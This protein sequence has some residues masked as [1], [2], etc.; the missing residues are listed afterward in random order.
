MKK[1]IYAAA[2]AVGLVIAWFVVS[3]QVAVAQQR[4]FLTGVGP[5]SRIGVSVRD[6][7][8][9]DADK[10]KLAQ[11]VGAFV[12]SV[13]ENSPAAKAGLQAGDIIL[14]VDGERVRSVRH[15]TRLVEESAPR[16]QVPVVIVRGTSKQ[17]LNVVPES[18]PFP[19]EFSDDRLR[20]LPRQLGEL[21]RRLPRGFDFDIDPN[22]PVPR[23]FRL[24]P[25]GP[26]LGVS[27]SPLTDQLAQYFGVTDGALVSSVEANTPA[28][29]AGLK[30]GDVITAIDG[31]TVTSAGDITDALR[32]ARGENVEISVTRERKSLTLKAT[33]ARP[34]SGR[35]GLPV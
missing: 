27:V 23:R 17:T 5:A 31:R 35:R 12:E 1:S 19:R 7:T 14:D 22:A 15:F 34:S 33:P 20:D 25:G 2:A 6:V 10:A 29:D 11:P 16:R 26:S 30:A 24:L 28:A 4:P 13:T 18:A 9:A 3:P 21:Q 8:S 32:N